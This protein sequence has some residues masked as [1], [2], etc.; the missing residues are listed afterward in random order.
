[1]NFKPGLLKSLIS[2]GVGVVA[3]FCVAISGLSGVYQILF[4]LI[5]IAVVYIVWSLLQAGTG[6]KYTLG[7]DEKKQLNKNKSK[8]KRNNKR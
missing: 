6:N 4:S 7:N 8:K 3:L 5:A 1:M 2:L